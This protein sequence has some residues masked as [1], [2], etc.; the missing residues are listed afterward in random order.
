M[1]EIN[2]LIWKRSGLKWEPWQSLLDVPIWL[3]DRAGLFLGF[4]NIPSFS[5][6]TARYRAGSCHSVNGKCPAPDLMSCQLLSPA[7]LRGGGKG[8][9]TRREGDIDINVRHCLW[10]N[11]WWIWGC[12]LRKNCEGLDLTLKDLFAFWKADWR[13]NPG[14]GYLDPWRCITCWEDPLAIVKIR[15]LC[16]LHHGGIPD[17]LVPACPSW[18]R[19][20]S[21]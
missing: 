9:G 14:T 20:S 8:S 21:K 11:T 6:D 5:L 2:V 4:W 10:G 15:K 19:A 16:R 3:S 12:L 17:Y 13:P 1:L 18:Y 7:C